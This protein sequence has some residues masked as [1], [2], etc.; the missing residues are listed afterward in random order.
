MLSVRLVPGERYVLDDRLGG[1]KH[2]V[3]LVRA[4]PGAAAAVVRCGAGAAATSCRPFIVPVC[5]LIGPWAD[6]ER[7]ICARLLAACRDA[8][9]P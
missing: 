9:P 1:G 8:G 4:G 5:W 2:Q 3:E 7:R 6:H